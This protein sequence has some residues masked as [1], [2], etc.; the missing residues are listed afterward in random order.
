VLITRAPCRSS[1]AIF[2]PRHLF[3]A[4]L[5]YVRVLRLRAKATQS[6]EHVESIFTPRHLFLALLKY[7]RVLRLRAKAT[8]SGEH[9]NSVGH[10]S[11]VQTAVVMP[12]GDFVY[13]PQLVNNQNGAKQVHDAALVP[14]H[15]HSL[16]AHALL[17]SLSFSFGT[18]FRSNFSFFRSS[19]LSSCFSLPSVSPNNS[20]PIPNDSLTRSVSLLLSRSPPPIPLS[21][22]PTAHPPP[23]RQFTPLHELKTNKT[24]PR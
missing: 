21:P 18:L 8:Q 9:V 23:R 17:F 10:T 16:P 3:L 14:L 6:G 7:V 2:T 19:F 24:W 4:L 11:Q 22:L 1:H 20:T 13:A 12:H 15:L 5:K